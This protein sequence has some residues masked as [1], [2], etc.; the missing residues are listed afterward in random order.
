MERRTVIEYE[1]FASPGSLLASYFNECEQPG[2]LF[3]LTGPSGSGKTT[4]CLS[5]VEHA[6]Q[7]EILRAGLVSPPVFE[8]GQRTGIDLLDIESEARARLANRRTAEIPSDSASTQPPQTSKIVTL[9]WQFNLETLEKGNE[10]L[11][12]LSARLE[13][14]EENSPKTLV[15]LDELGPLELVRRQGWVAGVDLITRRKYHLAFVVIRPGLLLQALD[16]WPWA[17]SLKFSLPT[18]MFGRGIQP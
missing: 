9:D 12:R 18:G 14:L 2:S 15:V 7:N 13:A 4:W 3:L 6:R 16:L 11:A 5:L 1:G 17:R 8:N 10:T